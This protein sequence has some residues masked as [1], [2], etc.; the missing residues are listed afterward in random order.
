MPKVISSDVTDVPERRRSVPNVG[1]FV[2]SAVLDF[3]TDH[4]DLGLLDD[5]EVMGLLIGHV[6]RDSGGTYALA[7][8]TVTGSLDADSVSVRFD[9]NSVSDLIDSLDGMKEGERVVGWYHSHLDHGCF[10]SETDVATQD[11]LFAGETGFA[12]VVDPVRG[13]LAV[14]DSEKGDPKKTDMIIMSDD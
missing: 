10:M 2:N 1:L 8:R 12:I 6:Y 11:S 7:E 4:A 13:E 9:R 14:F 5:R 3:I